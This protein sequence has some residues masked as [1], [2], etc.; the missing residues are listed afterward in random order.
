VP[1]HPFLDDVPAY[2][3]GALDAEAMRRLEE[4]L[5]SCETCAKELASLEDVVARLP[6]TLPQK[7]LPASLKAKVMRRISREAASS[8]KSSWRFGLLAAACAVLAAGLGLQWTGER[9]ERNALQSEVRSLREALAQKDKEL[10]WLKDPRVQMALLKGLE[11]APN[12]KAKLLFHPEK[13]HALLYIDGLPPLPIEKSYELWVFVKDEPLPSGVFD[14]R[15]GASVV[16][17]GKLAGAPEKRVKFAVSI[18]PRGG[19]PKPTGSI[20]LLG[21]SL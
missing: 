6:Y 21:E 8:S 19:V 5:L 14:A 18:E 13:E 12:A 16:Q 20:V 15:A 3:L 1:E 4:H 17:L 9:H 7:P 10:A 2:A 11:A